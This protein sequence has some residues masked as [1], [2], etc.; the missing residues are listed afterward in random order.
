MRERDIKKNLQTSKKHDE[1]SNLV[2]GIE[3]GKVA[4][5]E[6]DLVQEVVVTVVLAVPQQEAGDVS[7]LQRSS[8]LTQDGLEER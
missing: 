8:F 1:S 3:K 7:E 4:N 6:N 5:A 2:V